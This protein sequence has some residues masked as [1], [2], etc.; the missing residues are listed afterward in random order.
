[1][2]LSAWPLMMLVLNLIK[3]HRILSPDLHLLVTAT[4]L[5]FGIC[6]LCPLLTENCNHITVMLCCP[7]LWAQV[8]V[9]LVSPVWRIMVDV[10][11]F[12]LQESNWAAAV[13][14]RP[15]LHTAETASPL[16]LGLSFIHS[17]CRSTF[18]FEAE[19]YLIPSFPPP[20]RL[21]TTSH[22]V[23]PFVSLSSSHTFSPSFIPSLIIR[24]LQL[25]S[26]PAENYE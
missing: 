1:M 10:L 19:L 5:L 15:N 12:D 14:Q 13:N 22:L 23:L 25:T 20:Q 2:W 9:C 3:L 21:N 26:L 18:L 4:W 16:S 17:V 7:L 11:V 6:L 8:H 24:R